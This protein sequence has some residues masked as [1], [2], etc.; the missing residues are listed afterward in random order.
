MKRSEFKNLIRRELIKEAKGTSYESKLA[1]IEKQGHITTLE[2]K[3]D[4]LSEMIET[5]N[6]RLSLVSEDENLSELI[7]KKKIKEMQKEI[8]L[9]EKTKLK[10][11][12][13][14]E[15]KSGGKKKDVVI[16]EDARTDAEEEGY[17]DGMKDE[18]ED[19]EE[20]C[21]TY[22]EDDTDSMNEEFLRM[23]KLS[24]IISEEEYRNRLNEADFAGA[25][26]G[27]QQVEKALGEGA[28][29]EKSELKF[30]P[31]ADA[32]K[33]SLTAYFH[34]LSKDKKTQLMLW[35]KVGDDTSITWK[36]NAQQESVWNF[37]DAVK[38]DIER[39][40]T[41]KVSQSSA[42]QD[43]GKLT[44]GYGY[45]DKVTDEDVNAVKEG[46]KKLETTQPKKV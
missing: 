1:E 41:G 32:G 7:D 45:E 6:N 46:I 42:K 17:L 19:V 3:I 12:K 25:F 43:L 36:G 27:W 22:E 29:F 23:Q 21:S 9:L 18:K 37:I 30:R 13:L 35:V 34:F 16:D 38:P 26:G 2:A 8:K 4:A 10:L 31:E 39:Y 15:K 28:T 14:Y 44:V 40:L 33:S 5:K 20:A 11:E 24:G